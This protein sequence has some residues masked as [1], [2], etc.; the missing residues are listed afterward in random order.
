MYWECF[1]GNFEEKLQSFR[2]SQTTIMKTKPTY[3]D[4]VSIQKDMPGMSDVEK[5]YMRK[6]QA[7]AAQRAMDQKGL[8]GG[9]RRI[10][11]VCGVVAFS[12]CI[13]FARKSDQN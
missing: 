3:M 12:I 7:Q 10:G 5:Y 9:A 1:D 2:N 4:P 11:I 6:I 8:R 13:L